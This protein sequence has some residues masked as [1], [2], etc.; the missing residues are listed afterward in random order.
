M[1]SERVALQADV[2][3]RIVVGLRPLAQQ[4]IFSGRVIPYRGVAAGEGV[5][6][7]SI[8]LVQAG[9]NTIHIYIANIKITGSALAI[10]YRA[11]RHLEVGSG[12]IGCSAEVEHVIAR[13]RIAVQITCAGQQAHK[14]TCRRLQAV[15]RDAPI[16]LVV[17]PFYFSGGLWREGNFVFQ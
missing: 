9:L 2:V 16:P 8:E 15:K 4:R 13:D 7:G 1:V 3:T 6:L 14:I 12:V 10:D 17:D 5:K 11:V